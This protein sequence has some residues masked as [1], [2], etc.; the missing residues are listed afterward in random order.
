[1]PA[2]IRVNIRIEIYKI[3][4]I[5]FGNRIAYTFSYV[6]KPLITGGPAPIE[7]TM[8]VLDNNIAKVYR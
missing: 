5:W 2:N 1:M 8:I 6:H 3:G 7:R 4:F